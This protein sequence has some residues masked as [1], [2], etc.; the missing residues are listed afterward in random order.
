MAFLAVSLPPLSPKTPEK[1]NLLNSLNS[2]QQQ[3]RGTGVGSGMAA[4][5]SPERPTSGHHSDTTD[6][7]EEKALN[8]EASIFLEMMESLGA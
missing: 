2:Q 8:V 7:N 4:P 6:N 1:E 3:L 5:K